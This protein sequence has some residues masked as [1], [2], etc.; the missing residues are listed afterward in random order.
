MAVIFFSR[1]K[2]SLTAAARANPRKTFYRGSSPSGSKKSSTFVSWRG[3]TLLVL[4]ATA[5]MLGCPRRVNFAHIS[6]PDPGFRYDGLPCL[7]GSFANNL[8]SQSGP[9]VN[10]PVST[11][12]SQPNSRKCRTKRRMRWLPMLVMGGKE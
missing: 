11:T 5:G 1:I 10:L 2:C 8:S 12:G 4:V 6:V 3:K 9:V 7:P